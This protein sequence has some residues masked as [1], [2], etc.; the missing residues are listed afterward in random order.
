MVTE[1]QQP[2]PAPND[3]VAVRHFVLWTSAWDSATITRLQLVMIRSTVPWET[4]VYTDVAGGGIEITFTDEI[5]SGTYD[6]APMSRP[7][8]VT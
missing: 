3:T 1:S 5:G 4:W 6:Y 8:R 7:T 2:S